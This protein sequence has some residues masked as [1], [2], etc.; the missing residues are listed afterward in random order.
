M[1]YLRCVA[2]Y[3]L[4]KTF[5]RKSRQYYPG[6]T[7]S[8]TN[9][10]EPTA[11][12]TVE[13]TQPKQTEPTPLTLPEG[14]PLTADELAWFNNEFF[15]GVWVDEHPGW[16]YNTRNRYMQLEF[17]SVEEIDMGLLFRNGVRPT[18]DPVTQEEL[19]AFQQ[20]VGSAA[21]AEVIKIPSRD[22]QLAY[23]H[24]TSKSFLNS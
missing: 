11:E 7:E 4:C 10:T 21:S 8:G 5:N 6:Q 12:E 19:D 13:N 2:I 16:L 14:T 20:V 1:F 23:L 18:G 22:I 9:N 15:S 24:T 3:R 17:A